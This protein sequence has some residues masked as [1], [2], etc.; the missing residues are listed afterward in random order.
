MDLLTNCAIMNGYAAADG[1][2]YVTLMNDA[3]AEERR[4]HAIPLVTNGAGWRAIRDEPVLPWL[5]AGIAGAGPAGVAIVGWAGQVLELDGDACRKEGIF[6]RDGKPVAIIRTVATI[7]GTAYAAGLRR[8]VHRRAPDAWEELDAGA[9]YEGEEMEVGFE[10][11]GGFGPDDIYAAGLRGEIWHFESNRWSALQSPTNVHL[12]ALCCGADGVVTIGGRDGV[13]LQGRGD[14]WRVLPTTLDETI[15]DLH[16]FG[17]ELFLLTN[18]GVYRYADGEVEEQELPADE[19]CRFSS[20]PEALWLFGR[21]TIARYDG[22]L[23]HPQPT[24]Y[25]PAM[26]D[27]PALDYLAD[28]DSIFEADDDD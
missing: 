11:I 10:A 9:A 24:D 27:G 8:Q 5:A 3:L 20:T 14:R 13:L 22:A 17:S 15:W 28:D 23:W 7:A 2:L 19:Y 16:C 1:T 6:R 25:D 4:Q 18:D 12:H 26:I 21:K